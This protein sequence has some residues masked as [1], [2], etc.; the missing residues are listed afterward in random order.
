MPDDPI[1]ELMTKRAEQVSREIHGLLH[2]LGVRTQGAI[3]ADLVS[4]WLAGQ[5]VQSELGQP[6]DGD[7]P[8]TAAHRAHVFGEWVELVSDLVPESEKQMLHN[9]EPEGRG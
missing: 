1:A 9:V 2:G 3:L 4:L 6:L 5:I 8:L 7:R